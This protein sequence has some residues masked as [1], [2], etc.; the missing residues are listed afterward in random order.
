[1]SAG[2]PGPIN[3]TVKIT[4]LGPEENALSRCIHSRRHAATARRCWNAESS[5][6]G[7]VDSCCT[8]LGDGNPPAAAACNSPAAAHSQTA[9]SHGLD[10]ELDVVAGRGEVAEAVIERR[11]VV[12]GPATE[13]VKAPVR[14]QTGHRTS[15]NIAQLQRMVLAASKAPTDAGEAGAPPGAPVEQHPCRSL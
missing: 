5:R 14:G 13:R 10:V 2:N 3:H 11:A 7:E 1:M 12:A 4:S 9:G 8:R 15:T 6:A